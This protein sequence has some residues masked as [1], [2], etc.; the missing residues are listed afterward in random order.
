[1]T[2][3]DDLNAARA[4]L[5]YAFDRALRLLSPI[6]PF[7]TEALWQKLPGHVSDT[8]LVTAAW[9]TARTGRGNALDFELVQHLVVAVRQLRSDQ[10]IPPG[11]R[12]DL[13]IDPTHGRDVGATRAILEEEVKTIEHLTRSTVQFV[14]APPTETAVHGLSTDGTEFWMLT[15]AADVAK[16]CAKLRQ[17]LVDLEKQLAGL[18]SRLQNENFVSRAKPDVVEAERKKEGELRARREQLSA[19]VASL[20]GA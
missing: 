16:Q 13:L 20:C 18:Q 14:S 12:V 17:E 1:M 10:Q 19:K 11:K 7:V 8:F 2:P 4:V 6:V 3:G 5:V 15:D 9:P